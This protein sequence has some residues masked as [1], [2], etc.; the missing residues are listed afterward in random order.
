VPEPSAFEVEL[1]IEDLI[2]TEQ[3]WLRQGRT[4]CYEVHKCIISIL[5]KEE[6]PEKWKELIIVPIYKSGDKTVCSNYR[7]LSLLPTMY[8]ILSKICFKFNSICRINYLYNILKEFGIPL[9]LV[10]LIKLCLTETNSR[11]Q[12]G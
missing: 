12:V 5:D 7:G 2:K 4:I 1:A 6:F 11:V 3:N 9:K 10:K 8:K